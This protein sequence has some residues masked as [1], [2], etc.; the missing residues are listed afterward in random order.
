MVEP[1]FEWDADAV[2]RRDRA[3]KRAQIATAE[4][5][6]TSPLDDDDAAAATTAAAAAAA[7]ST[8]GQLAYALRTS[9]GLVFESD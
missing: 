8:E 9:H 2:K 7:A 5:F 6:Q 1:K 4:L 3:V